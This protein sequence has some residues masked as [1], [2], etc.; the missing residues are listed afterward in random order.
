MTIFCSSDSCACC[1]SQIARWSSLS[2]SSSWCVTYGVMVSTTSTSNNDTILGCSSRYWSTSSF[3]N[4][5]NMLI[6]SALS[7]KSAPA[8]RL[9]AI[10]RVF[11]QG[12]WIGWLVLVRNQPLFRFTIRSFL[13]SKTLVWVERERERE[14]EIEKIFAAP[15]RCREARDTCAKRR[16]VR[17]TR[18]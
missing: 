16:D 18:V 11:D 1:S 2:N 9:N 8:G 7:R 3:D 17:V 12:G 6:L 10:T 4:P 15:Q 5:S 14:R 13:L